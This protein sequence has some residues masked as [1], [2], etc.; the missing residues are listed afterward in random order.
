[1]AVFDQVHRS[2]SL[3][4]RI[5]LTLIESGNALQASKTSTARSHGLP[6]LQASLLI[7][8]RTFNGTGGTVSTLAE[9]LQLT[10]P[11]ISDSMKALVRKGYLSRQRSS[12]DGRV[13]YFRLTRKGARTADQMI[14]W[15]DPV[16]FSIADMNE[17]Q[18]RTFLG[19]LTRLLREYVE[20]GFSPAEAM[21]ASCSFFEVVSWEKNRYHCCRRDIPLNPTNLETDCPGHSP[22]NGIG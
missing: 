11:T 12:D 8:L 9:A 18:Q 4:A 19:F 7:H 21:C 14:G 17:S 5:A 2:E 22:C 10:P 20:K 1:M 15:A 6:T 16:E 13:A 3:P